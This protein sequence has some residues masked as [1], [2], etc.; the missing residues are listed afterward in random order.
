MIKSSLGNFEYYI[1]IG[2]FADRPTPAPVET[3]A[4]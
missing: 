3:E 4:P 1:G 2:P